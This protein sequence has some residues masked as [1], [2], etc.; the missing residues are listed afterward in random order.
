MVFRLVAFLL[1]LRFLHQVLP[2]PVSAKVRAFLRL[3]VVKPFV[4]HASHTGNRIFITVS[5][6]GHGN[7]RCLHTEILSHCKL[8]VVEPKKRLN[9]T[10]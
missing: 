4:G 2:F 1:A 9:S 5:V 8:V 7:V 3:D 10:E 6:A